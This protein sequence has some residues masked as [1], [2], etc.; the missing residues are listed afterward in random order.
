[1]ARLAPWRVVDDRS[2]VD[3]ASWPAPWIVLDFPPPARRHD[4]WAGRHQGR[5]VGWFQTAAVGEDV[6]QAG[7][8][9]DRVVDRLL[10]WVPVIDGWPSVWPV[11][12]DTEPRVLDASSVPDRMLVQ[13]V[14]RWTW[15]AERDT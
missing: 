3:D 7:R 12:M 6:D 5:A 11:E 4:R 1:M 15:Q 9:H 8:L 10:D 13:V 2:R 14:T